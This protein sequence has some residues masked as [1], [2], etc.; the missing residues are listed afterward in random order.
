MT[1]SQE[2][3]ALR[4]QTPEA[5]QQE[6]EQAH[7]ALFNLRFQAATRQLADVG[8]IGKAK[9]RIARAKTLLRERAILAEVE[10][11]RNASAQAE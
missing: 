7:Q 3:R 1:Q 4:E 8:Q 11:A 6:L 5:L 9:K 2:T 10:A